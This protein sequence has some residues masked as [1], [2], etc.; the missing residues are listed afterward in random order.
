VKALFAV[1]VFAVALCLT[2]FAPAPLP[3]RERDRPGASQFFGEWRITG[4]YSIRGGRHVLLGRSRVTHVRISEGQWTFLPDDYAGARLGLAIDHG[5]E[6]AQLTFYAAGDP[7][8]KVHGVGLIRRQGGELQ[9]LYTWGG[10]DKRPRTFEPAPDGYYFR[11]LER[12]AHA[13]GPR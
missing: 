1:A 4:S 10:E 8:R 7:K 13:G 3:R 2:A 12:S 11:T 6:P 9:V 5:K